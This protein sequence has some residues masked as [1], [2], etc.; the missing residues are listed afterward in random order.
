MIMKIVRIKN[1]TNDIVT[2]EN[3]FKC[4]RLFINQLFT[5][6]SFEEIFNNLYILVVEKGAVISIGNNNGFF[7]LTELGNFIHT[8]ELFLRKVR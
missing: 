5:G 6:L 4:N 7:D 1:M 3:G 8:R 2:F